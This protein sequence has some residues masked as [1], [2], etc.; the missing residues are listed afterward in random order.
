MEWF[1]V[2]GTCFTASCT[3]SSTPSLTSTK[4]LCGV[5]HGPSL[6][7]LVFD[8]MTSQRVL[9]Q[10]AFAGSLRVSEAAM[11]HVVTRGHVGDGFDVFDSRE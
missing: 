5:C 8:A 7:F 1:I 3:V 9:S 2:P 11:S 10:R 6:S 4:A